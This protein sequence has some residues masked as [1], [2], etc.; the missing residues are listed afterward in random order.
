M[1][2][3]E[4]RSTRQ[5]LSNKFRF[6]WRGLRR[7]VRSESNFFVH[8]FMAVMVIAVAAV[9]GCTLIEWS[10]LVLCIGSVLA[11]EMFN[12]ALEHLVKDISDK[13]TPFLADALDMASA[14]VLLTA[15]ASAIVGTLVLGRRLGILLNWWSS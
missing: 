14:A 11:A 6:A 7:G 10:L 1:A 5:S 3:R 12:T 13:R 8:L 9:L 2:R 4:V 15:V